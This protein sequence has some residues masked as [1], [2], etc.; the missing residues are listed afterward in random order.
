MLSFRWAAR[1]ID[2]EPG[3]GGLETSIRPETRKVKVNRDI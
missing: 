3:D 2:D 1:L